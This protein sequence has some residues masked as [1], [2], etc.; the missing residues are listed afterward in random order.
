M[1]IFNVAQVTRQEIDFLIVPLHA[2]FEFKSEQERYATVATL[3]SAA[4]RAGLRGIVVPIWASRTGE[5]A[6]FAEVHHRAI[7]RSIDLEFVS[8]NINK[9]IDVWD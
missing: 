4:N 7:L 3:R 2:S 1:A 8:H 9:M 6:S 5:M